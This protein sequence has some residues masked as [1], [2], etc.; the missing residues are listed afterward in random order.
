MS[1]LFGG[2]SALERRRSW[3]GLDEEDRLQAAAAL[4]PREGLLGSLS[5]LGARVAEALVAKGEGEGLVEALASLLAAKNTLA[6]TLKVLAVREYASL[7]GIYAWRGQTGLVALGQ[8]LLRTTAVTVWCARVAATGRSRS[9]DSGVVVE[10][11]IEGCGRLLGECPPQMTVLL[12]AV[13]TASGGDPRAQ[14]LFV[15]LRLLLPF[16]CHPDRLGRRPSP[17]ARARQLGVARR[18]GQL[19]AQLEPMTALFYAPALQCLSLSP[20]SLALAVPV[21]SPQAARLVQ[22]VRAQP[23][24]RASASP[25]EEDFWTLLDNSG[26][27]LKRSASWN[28]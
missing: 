24:L 5:H 15:W 9:N 13:H 22:W 27:L 1:S 6:K 12:Q 26:R 28:R 17:S 2:A 18:L 10:A 19:A 4:A 16:L 8:V 3:S 11:L 14:G 23:D 7:D 25:A 21:D 20:S